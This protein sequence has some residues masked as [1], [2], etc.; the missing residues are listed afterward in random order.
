MYVIN[1]IACH[2]KFYFT[3]GI[4]FKNYETFNKTNFHTKQQFSDLFLKSLIM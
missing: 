3:I 4:L 1:S 2:N